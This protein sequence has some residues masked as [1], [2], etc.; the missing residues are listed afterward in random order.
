M[1][2]PAGRR[3][4]KLGLVC[5][6]LLLL[7]GVHACSSVPLQQQRPV[8]SV[9]GGQASPVLGPV[10]G[11]D[12]DFV[13][14][15]AQNGDDLKSLAERYL[16]DSRKAW[17]IA[18]F[19]GIFS[20]QPGQEVVIPLRARNPVGVYNAG[21]Q[22][23]PILTYHRLGQ[24]RSRLVVSPAAFEAQMQYLAGNGYHVIPLRQLTGFLQGVEPLPRKT[25]VITLDDAYRSTYEI[26]YPL[27][28]K[29]GFPATVF[30]YSDFVGAADAMTWPQMQELASSG[31]VDIQPHSKS[32]GN[33]ALRLPGETDAQYHGRLRKE[34]EAPILAIRARLAT[35]IYGY[36]FP[37][38]D[39]NQDITEQLVREGIPLG[40][41]VTPGGNGFFANPFMLRR[42][43]IYGEDDLEAFKSKLA[44]FT[45]MTLR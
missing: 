31:L 2:L 20:V 34:I 5:A 33:L 24:T 41:T 32:H 3:L 17:W 22:T 28:K 6:C 12:A 29:H 25:V 16:G 35:E 43:M 19:N 38:G 10:L 21:I 13:V 27:L 37:Y 4:R 9:Q 18:E 15:L 14:V 44:V 26:A 40:L 30:L 42:T 1:N 45:T 11:K 23:V 8:T 7:P 36:A 39:T